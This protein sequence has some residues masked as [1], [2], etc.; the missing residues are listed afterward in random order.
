MSYFGLFA[1]PFLLGLVDSFKEVF[2]TRR[3]SSMSSP[4]PQPS[5]TTNRVEVALVVGFSLPAR[6]QDSE[7]TIS[8]AVAQEAITLVEQPSV[9]EAESTRVE[10]VVPVAQ[11]PA[12]STA[13]VPNV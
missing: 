6:S 12:A 3:S 4:S 2:C 7:Q 13:G 5:S 11:N 8:M 1:Q 10:D 9:D